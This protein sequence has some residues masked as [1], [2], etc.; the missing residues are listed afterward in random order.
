M[1]SR[2]RCDLLQHAFIPELVVEAFDVRALLQLTGFD[3]A[4]LQLPAIRSF[5]DNLEYELWTIINGHRLRQPPNFGQAF[6]HGRHKASSFTTL[7]RN[8]YN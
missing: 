8:F 6:Q 1:N 7:G 4:Q 2:L 3:E 5:V